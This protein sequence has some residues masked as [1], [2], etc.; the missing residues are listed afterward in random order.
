MQF[1]KT[2][3]I[4]ILVLAGTALSSPVPSSSSSLQSLNLELPSTPPVSPSPL[5]QRPQGLISQIHDCAHAVLSFLPQGIF[6]KDNPF[7]FKNGC[8]LF[9]RPAR[10]PTPPPA[11]AVDPTQW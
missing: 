9:K 6:H 10:P 3:T 11:P 4:T 7:G 2:A 1:F 8:P 5:P